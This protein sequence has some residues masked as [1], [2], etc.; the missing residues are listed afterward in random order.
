MPSNQSLRAALRRLSTRALAPLLLLAALILTPPA[1]L[2]AQCFGPDLLDLG[3]CCQPA[4]L[5]LPAFSSVR[6]PSLGI[7][8]NGCTVGTTNTLSVEW[9][10]PTQPFCGQFSTQITVQDAGTGTA[11]MVGKLTLD[12]TRTWDEIDATGNLLQVWRFVAKADLATL[13]GAPPVCPTPNCIMPAGPHTTAFYY[14]YVDYAGCPGGVVENAIVLFHN[15]DRFIHQPGLSDKPGNFHL[16]RSYAIV[17]PHSATQPFVPN[18]QLAPIGPVIAEATRTVNSMPPTT[19]CVVEDRVLTASLISHGAGCVNTMTSNPKQQSLRQFSC[20]TS[21]VNA[22]GQNGLWASL[23][24]NFPTLPWFHMVSSSIGTWSSPLAYPGIESAWA[25]EGLFVHRDACSG[26]FVE[27]K[28]GATTRDG[29]T[30][31]L[32]T[33]PGPVRVFTDLADNWSAPLLGPYS[34]PI[35]GSFQP[36]NHLI[37]V[38]TP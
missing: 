4:A 1:S 28:Y 25:D 7:C 2:S 21:C 32:P 9:P 31:L 19:A 34:L 16:G 5:N 27:L 15:G 36:T 35:M 14:G 30:A 18:N 24:V 10:A 26:D 23:N 29:Y 13:P 37:Y 11:L 20:Q 38:N 17:G 3:A 8:W 33:L 12:Y 6:L 22:I